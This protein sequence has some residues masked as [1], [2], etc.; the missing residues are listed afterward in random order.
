[1]K[2]GTVATSYA[3]LTTSGGQ[4]PGSQIPGDPMSDRQV[5]CDT[6]APENGCSSTSVR[7]GIKTMKN[8]VKI[9]I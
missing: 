8:Q 2:A 5:S 3:N 9:S 1:M 7:Q 4:T 6:N